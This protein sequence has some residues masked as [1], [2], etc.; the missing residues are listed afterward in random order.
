VRGASADRKGIVTDTVDIGEAVG[1][2]LEYEVLQ[3]G[4]I[5]V[6][7]FGFKS[8]E[9]RVSSCPTIGIQLATASRPVGRYSSTVWIPGH[10]FGEGTVIVG[11][12]LVREA[13]F[14]SIVTVRRRWPFMSLR[15][16][17]GLRLAAIIPVTFRGKFDPS[18]VTT[19]YNSSGIANSPPAGFFSTARPFR[20]GELQ[21]GYPFL[22]TVRRM[23]RCELR[24]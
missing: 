24:A 10:F 5:L 2:E 6:P 11:G 8:D 1:V 21:R 9:G 3:P 12:G 18:K 14:M 20:A 16:M 19:N 17:R 22:D 4:H 7:N 13:R 15:A 23:R